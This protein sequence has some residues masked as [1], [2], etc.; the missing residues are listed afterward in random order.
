[1]MT[2]FIEQPI[3]MPGS[4][5]YFTICYKFIDEIYFTALLYFS[6][7]TDRQYMPC[8]L[9]VKCALRPVPNTFVK[10]LT[11][12][13][14]LCFMKFMK[15]SLLPQTTVVEYWFPEFWLQKVW[16]FVKKFFL[17]ILIKGF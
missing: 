3:A 17:I 9:F 10:H 2:M 11:K 8:L 4:D 6:E 16:G 15:F 5:N 13:P 14:S 1:M 12:Y 7:S